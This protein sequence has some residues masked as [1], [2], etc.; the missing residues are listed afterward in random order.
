VGQNYY[1]SY[2]QNRKV[3]VTLRTKITIFHV[4]TYDIAIDDIDTDKVANTLGISSEDVR[5][6]E[7][8]R[9][10]RPGRASNLSR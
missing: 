4:D 8:L 2:R 3:R 10:G 5:A 1:V 7:S 6:E 9:G